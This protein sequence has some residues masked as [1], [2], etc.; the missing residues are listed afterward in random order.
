MGHVFA[1]KRE[2]AVYIDRSWKLYVYDLKCLKETD[3]VP[4]NLLFTTIDLKFNVKKMLMN[5]SRIVCLSDKNI[6]VVDVKHIDRLR[7]PESC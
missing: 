6:Y 4:K 3:V 2:T 1:Q 5:E 7:C